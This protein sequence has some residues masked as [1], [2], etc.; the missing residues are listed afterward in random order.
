MGVKAD[1]EMATLLYAK[2]VVLL[3][4]LIRGWEDDSVRGYLAARVTRV[5]QG[6]ITLVERNPRPSRL[7]QFTALGFIG[8]VQRRDR[9]PARRVADVEPLALVC[10]DTPPCM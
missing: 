6:I 5:I 7:F 2:A 4:E 9:P 10:P 8:I 3:R 1:V